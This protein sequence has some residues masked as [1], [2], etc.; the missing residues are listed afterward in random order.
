MEI[1]VFV[2]RFRRA[3]PWLGAALC[4]AP[5][6][7]A[8]SFPWHS[9][10]AG[11][12]LARVV[13]A[14][15]DRDGRLDAIATDTLTPALV[16]LSG[17]LPATFGLAQSFPLSAVPGE[18]AVADL[19]GDGA[20]D[21]VAACPS[22]KTLALRMSDPPFGLLAEE[23]LDQADECAGLALVDTNGDGDVDVVCTRR[24]TKRLALH[25]N[26]GSGNF[27]NPVLH[28]VTLQVELLVSAD[29][30]GD[31]K[32]DF[33]AS[34]AKDDDPDD[35]RL[36]WIRKST[37]TSYANEAHMS[38]AKGVVGIAA[39][40]FDLDG[41][42]DAV[43]AGATFDQATL[44]R[45][46]GDGQVA[47]IQ[48]F[49]IASAP[50]SVRAVD[51]D[52][53]GVPDLVFAH[54]DGA[55]GIVQR[56][57]D[58]NGVFTAIGAG[59]PLGVLC[60]DAQAVDLDG[61][62]SIDFVAARDDGRLQVV[63]GDGAGGSPGRLEL[64]TGHAAHFALLD[65]D[66]LPDL[67]LEREGILYVH[68]GLP[69]G[70]YGEPISAV[71]HAPDVTH[72]TSADL[73]GDSRLDL[74]A[75]DAT[76]FSV[77]WYRGDGSGGFTPAGEYFSGSEH[78]RIVPGDYDGD[79]RI[80]LLLVDPGASGA[81]TRLFLNHLGDGYMLQVIVDIGYCPCEELV[82]LDV[83]KDGRTDL[84][85]ALEPDGAAVYLRGLGSAGFSA[86][87]SLGGLTQV[88][89]PAAGDLNLDGRIDLVYSAAPEGLG[90]YML[91]GLQ[92]GGFSAP[93]FVETDFVPAPR[94]LDLS[95][96][97]R[98][99]LLS[100]NT[101][102]AASANGSFVEWARYEVP[103]GGPVVDAN[104]DGKLDLLVVAD[105]GL[106]ETYIQLNLVGDSAG[107]H[108]FGSGVQG[109]V[110]PHE[111]SGFGLPKVGQPNFGLVGSAAPAHGF[112]V[113][114]VA[115]APHY[116]GAA[117]LGLGVELYVDVGAAAGAYVFPLHA[118][119]SGHVLR[120]LPVP[121]ATELVGVRVWSQF[122]W[123]WPSD[124]CQPS[125]PFG[126]S[127]TPGLEIELQP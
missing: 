118:D 72:I 79:G 58:G 82:A 71:E 103:T 10:P 101:L 49:S 77:R 9:R 126:L 69:S 120:M 98:L 104:G 52:A 67:V 93:Y 2:P 13:L 108:S 54:A 51:L 14:D 28:L 106:S 16:V 57:N 53:D 33:L 89:A 41:D 84:V 78:A 47:Q 97:G 81:A 121:P 1:H 15:F 116:G 88:S 123:L 96:D 30:D 83:D 35:D 3:A 19:N 8:Q 31:G 44:L 74:I 23:N 85:R 17:R 29:L 42:I 75:D 66:A 43:V 90:F 119:E 65:A 26:D 73:D 21:L 37:G 95:G 63:L 105:L 117:A 87:L 36:S 39:A 6:L 91:L 114:F 32:P 68:P 62:A 109:C 56:R 55:H 22:E 24:S 7:C 38:C 61:D 4:C 102:W 107:L 80:D 18:L 76:G 48:D 59:Y 127:S 5:Q 50:R 122:L 115:A 99:D 11:A 110:G 124:G 111:L 40:D 46:N 92:Q 125:Q 12:G 34:S 25:E 113:G 112:G 45:G 70:G 20:L 100:G 64:P 94:L 86:P 27:A 60:R